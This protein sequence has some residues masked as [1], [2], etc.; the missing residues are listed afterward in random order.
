M[1]ALKS[2]IEICINVDQI[3]KAQQIFEYYRQ[4]SKLKD[5]TKLHGDIEIY[6]SLIVGW[7]QKGKLDKVK[8]IFQ[9]MSSDNI[10]PNLQSYAGYL[11]CISR[12]EF[13]NVPEIQ[14]VINEMHS[15]GLSHQ[16]ILQKCV[17]VGDQREKVLEILGFVDANVAVSSNEMSESYSCSL[18]RKLNDKAYGRGDRHPN[19]C[20]KEADIQKIS[21]SQMQLENDYSI[22]IK[23]VVALE[24][25]NEKVKKSRNYLKECEDMWRTKLTMALKNLKY[26]KKYS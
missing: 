11:E 6:N 20:F 13:I 21:T 14:N 19:F 1:H 12:R 16:D 8:Q 23:S 25:V 10:A 4:K 9:F 5:S 18:L 22:R 24:D 26:M 3:E 17:F 15:K 7:A 2:Y